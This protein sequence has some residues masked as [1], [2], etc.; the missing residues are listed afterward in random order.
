METDCGTLEE[1]RAAQNRDGGWPYHKGGSWTE[2]TVYALLAHE[3]GGAQLPRQ[4]EAVAWLGRA[5]RPDGGF[6][7]RLE[8]DESTWVTA[9]AAL[10]P[11]EVIGAR[12][13][14]RAVEWLLART[15]MQS[16]ALFRLREFLR[17]GALSSG[18]DV[19]GWPWYPGTAAWVTPTSLGILA[20]QKCY[21][22]RPAS[23]LRERIAEARAFLFAHQCTDGGWN[24]GSER[25]LGYDLGSYPETTGQAL[26]ALRGT[27]PARLQTALGRAQLFLRE[28]WS[29]A[30]ASWLRL[31]LLAHG[32]LPP[33]APRCSMPCRTLPDSAL[34]LIAG[35]AEQGYNV[36]VG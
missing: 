27:D 21:W 5:Q 36:L 14:A 4:A 6:A 9:L 29:S 32:Q 13:H 28:P 35:A 17:N 22:R 10:L 25:A 7:P 1:I 19:S 3:A 23:S 34:A 11:E 8:V 15:G 20:L 2:P 24:H 18:P 16:S 26:L 12:R 33:A 30:G 31:G